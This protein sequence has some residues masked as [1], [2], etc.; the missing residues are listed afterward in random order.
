MISYYLAKLIGA[1]AIASILIPWY[2][3]GDDDCRLNIFFT[4]NPDLLNQTIT[5]EFNNRVLKCINNERG[6]ASDQNPNCYTCDEFVCALP[7]VAD[8]YNFVS[9]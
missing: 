3:F 1:T 7:C 2:V 5:D 6:N 4:A 8:Q 9:I